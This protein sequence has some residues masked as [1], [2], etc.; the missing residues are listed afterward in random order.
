MKHHITSI[1]LLF[2]VVLFTS[3]CASPPNT[4]TE[5]QQFR[6]DSLYEHTL[7]MIELS[8]NDVLLEIGLDPSTIVPNENLSPD[9][10]LTRLTDSF[11]VTL[12]GN[13]EQDILALEHRMSQMM[14]VWT[15][16]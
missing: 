13:T 14:Q 10:Q 1:F 16:E 4:F 9:E 12:S 8:S 2:F 11:H 15:Y 7:I 6:I 5:D 3:G